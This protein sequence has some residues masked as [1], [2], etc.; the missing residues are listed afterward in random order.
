LNKIKE[1]HQEQLLLLKDKILNLKS[2]YSNINFL[3]TLMIEDIEKIEHII[4]QADIN[5]NWSIVG[6]MIEEL[7]I[8]LSIIENLLDEN[9]RNNIPIFSNPINKSSEILYILIYNTNILI[10]NEKIIPATIK[11]KRTL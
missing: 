4:I 8:N 6:S 9:I 5:S 11:L 7:N 10:Q 3:I 1:V 2:L